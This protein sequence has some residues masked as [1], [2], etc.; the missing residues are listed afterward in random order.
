[1]ATSNGG[2]ALFTAT[3][4]SLKMEM[5]VTQN[6]WKWPMACDYSFYDGYAALVRRT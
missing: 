3:P 1:M 5:M 4:A 2:F 6:G